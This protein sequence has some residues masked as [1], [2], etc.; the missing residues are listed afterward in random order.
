MFIHT[1]YTLIQSDCN[2]V[3]AVMDLVVY[4]P[5]AGT[6]HIYIYIEREREKERERERDIYVYI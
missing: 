3:E 1:Y 2:L 4:W 5:G 6:A